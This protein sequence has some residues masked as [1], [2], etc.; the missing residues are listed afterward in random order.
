MNFKLW[1]APYLQR[2]VISW[3]ADVFG[4]LSHLEGK[5]DHSIG[6][7]LGCV[8]YTSCYHVCVSNGLHL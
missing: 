6:V 2:L 8:E 3:P 5:L 7:V 1:S 4:Y